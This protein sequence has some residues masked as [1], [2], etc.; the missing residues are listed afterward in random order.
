MTN[1]F[2]ISR[3]RQRIKVVTD[4]NNATISLEFQQL[5]LSNLTSIIAG[6]VPASGVLE[7]NFKV[8]TAQRGDF[9][10]KLEIHDLMI[11]GKPWGDVTFTLAHS[12]DRYDLEMLVKSSITNVK[13]TGHYISRP[14]DSEFDLAIALAPLDMQ[15]IEPLSL[16]KLKNSKGQATGNLKIT[17]TPGKPSIRGDVNFKDVYFTLKDFNSSFTLQDERIS[18]QPS[19]IAFNNFTIRDEKNQE[20]TIR[21]SILTEF[22]KNLNL[23]FV[24]HQR[25]FSC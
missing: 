23:I 24:S 6:Q 9:D 11:L 8:T 12:A 15:T 10:S 14:V 22:I 25:I 2:S 20:A 19:G 4:E 18:F 17:G 3:E 21:G 13:A 1:N 5:E 16:G 7:G